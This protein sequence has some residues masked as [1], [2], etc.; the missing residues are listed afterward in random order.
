MKKNIKM[1]NAKQ[2]SNGA[3]ATVL[4]L[5]SAILPV[6]SQILN[7]KILPG[8]MIAVAKDQVQIFFL[9]S[10]L[11]KFSK[12]KFQQSDFFFIFEPFGRRL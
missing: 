8:L 11:K 12:F 6:M 2:A 3:K 7:V 4:I 5:M 9:T 10:P 1:S